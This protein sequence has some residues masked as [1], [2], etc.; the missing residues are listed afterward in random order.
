LFLVILLFLA[1]APY[2]KYRQRKN[3]E[4]IKSYLEKIDIEEIHRIKKEREK[5]YE[6]VFKEK[7]EREV[8]GNEE[9]KGGEKNTEDEQKIEEIKEDLSQEEKDIL[10]LIHGIPK[11]NVIDKIK[12]FID[13]SEEEIKEI[14]DRLEKLE[15]INIMKVPKNEI[16]EEEYYFRTTKVKKDMLNDL[17]R[18]EK[19]FG[20]DFK[21]TEEKKEE[22]EK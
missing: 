19:D 4:I 15:L 16:E 11:E 6:P 14:L 2:R 13:F 8:E 5:Y 7:T 18:F 17:L 20:W 12:E 21:E 9:D 22:D 3:E 1:L 10:T